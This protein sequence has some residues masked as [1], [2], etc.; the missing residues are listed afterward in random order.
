MHRLATSFCGGNP[1][2]ANDSIDTGTI[3]V[4]DLPPGR[5]KIMI[6][7]VDGNREKQ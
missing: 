7:L 2:Y 1:F 3:D 6:D 4:M 5:H